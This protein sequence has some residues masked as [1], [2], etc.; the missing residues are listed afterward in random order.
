MGATFFA[1]TFFFFCDHF[2]DLKTLAIE[3]KLIINNA[4]D[5]SLP[6]Y[7]QNIYLIPN[8]LLFGRQVLCNSN[9]TSTVVRTLTVFSGTADKINHIS[10]HFWHWWKH[11]YVVNLCETQRASKSNINSKK[12]VMLDY[13][14]MVPRHF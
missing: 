11:E 1:I 4:T 6:K 9:T 7:Y 3:F 5:I 8:H 12:I 13:D 10:N 14:E 2:E